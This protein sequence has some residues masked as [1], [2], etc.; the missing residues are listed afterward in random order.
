M[1]K[2]N[3]AWQLQIGLFLILLSFLLYALHYLLF[4]DLHHIYIYL[5]G[6]I[7][8]LPIEVLLVTLILHKLLSDH[9]KQI[10]LEK[11]NMVIGTFFS[12][13]GTNLL[14]YFSDLDPNLATIKKYLLVKDNWTEQ[15][16]QN[17]TAQ[18]KQHKYDIEIGKVN[19]ETLKN[20]L[21]EKRD[22]LLR[23]LENPNLLEH[24]TFTELLRAVFHLAEEMSQ[25]K[26][27]K[28]LVLN[29]KI[30]LAG[31]IKRVYVLLVLEW[32]SYMRH[33][34]DNFPY[35]FSLAMRTNPFDETAS[36]EIK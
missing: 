1:K 30:H 22:F 36:P 26:K 25:R 3:I 23:L 28:E 6:D 19:L 7:A 12:E 13:I 33:L 2:K 10:R 20:F 24:E 14:T 18:L 35:L 29:D 11:L 15:E 17:C 34:K 31:D 9:E 21:H 4:G 16:F 5:L 27:I 8:F 32:L